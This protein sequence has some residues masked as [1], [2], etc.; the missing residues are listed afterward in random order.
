MSEAKQV[1]YSKLRG[2]AVEKCHTLSALAEKSGIRLEL[3]SL[4]M[5]GKREFSRSEIMKICETLDIR[6][7]DIGIYYFTQ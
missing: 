6:P 2:L 4:A 7:E 1:N 3:I 5:N